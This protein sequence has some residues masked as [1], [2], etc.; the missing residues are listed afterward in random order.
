MKLYYATGSC[1]LAVHILLNDIGKP[2][3]LEK[4]DLRTHQTASGKD[5]YQINPKG[6]VPVLELDNGEILTE[7]PAIVQYITETTQ[8]YDLFPEDGLAKTRVIEWL[9]FIGSEIHKHFTPLFNVS[10]PDSLKDTAREAITKR[11]HYISDVLEKSTYLT[12]GQLSIADIYLFVILG[13]TRSVN[14]D[15]SAWKNLEALKLKVGNT[16]AVQQSLK[17]QGLI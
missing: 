10:S 9:A 12:G 13:W 8:S 11:F 3:E 4:V 15:I 5:F 1:A 16:P 17:E 2:F 14:F 7:L 6:Y